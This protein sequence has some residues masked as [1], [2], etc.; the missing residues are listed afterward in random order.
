MMRKVA[1]DQPGSSAEALHRRAV[2]M[3][4]FGGRV[5][6]DAVGTVAAALLAELYVEGVAHGVSPKDWEA[7]TSLPLACLEVCRVQARR[8]RPTRD[9]AVRNA[10]GQPPLPFPLPPAVQRLRDVELPVRA[11]AR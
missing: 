6:L 4:A 2:M 1:M 5:P 7:V 10:E 3:I 9:G 11:R 8:H